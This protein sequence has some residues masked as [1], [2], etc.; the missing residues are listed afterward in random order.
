MFS[1][2]DTVPNM[3]ARRDGDELLPVESEHVIAWPTVGRAAPPDLVV[4]AGVAAGLVIEIKASSVRKLADRSGVSRSTIS[5]I[6][7]GKTW[8]STRDV[9]RLEAATGRSLWTTVTMST[10][11]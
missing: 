8:P 2:S 10:R 6:V 9:A 11:A 7:N 3:P 5:R 4:A 1:S